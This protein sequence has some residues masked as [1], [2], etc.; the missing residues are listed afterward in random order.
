MRISQAAS[1]C[2]L[3]LGYTRASGRSRC[4]RERKRFTVLALHRRAGKT[5][6]AIMELLDKA[7]RFSVDA[8]ALLLRRTVPEASEAD[9]V[10]AAQ[11]ARC[12][13]LE[14]A[15]ACDGERVRA[16]GHVPPQRRDQVRVYGGDNPD[17]MR[18]VRLDGA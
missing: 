8:R 1:C 9:R 12:A 18:G 17:G 16:I 13:P 4:H 15:G 7:L 6:L 10:G 5:E 14:M 2:R 11:A 3:S